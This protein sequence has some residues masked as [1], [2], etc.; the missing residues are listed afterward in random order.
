MPKKRLSSNQ[1]GK[2][3]KSSKAVSDSSSSSDEDQVRL[4]VPQPTQFISLM[5]YTCTEFMMAFPC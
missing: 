1:S 2:K 4:K 5:L 3:R